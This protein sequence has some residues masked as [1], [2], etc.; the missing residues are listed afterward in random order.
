MPGSVVRIAVKPGQKVAR[1]EVLACVEAMKMES[2]LTAEHDG[3]MGAVCVKVGDAVPAKA[4]L[5]E[6]H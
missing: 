5:M 3:T 6:L 1:G 2:L 4:L